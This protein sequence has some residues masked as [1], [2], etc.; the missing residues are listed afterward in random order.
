MISVIYDSRNDKHPLPRKAEMHLCAHQRS[1]AKTDGEILKSLQKAVD[2]LICSQKL[3]T[4]GLKGV[5][6]LFLCGPELLM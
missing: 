2:G 3:A 4:S 5:T 1:L 6:F